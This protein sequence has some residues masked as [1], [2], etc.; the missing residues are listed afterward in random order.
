MGMAASQARY[1]GLQARKTN[2]EF[3][4]QQV[5][6]Q[7]TAL[8]NESAGLFRRM[9]TLNV[10]TPPD[11]TDYKKGNYTFTDAT[12]TNGKATIEDIVKNEGSDPPTYTLNIKRVVDVPQ[13]GA[14]TNQEVSV[15]KDADTNKYKIYNKNGTAFDLTGPISPLSETYVNEFNKLGATEYENDKDDVYYKYTNPATNAT[16][17]INATE[18]GF[19]PE[20]SNTQNVDFFTLMSGQEEQIETIENAT[21]GTTAD[22]A[23]NSIY[24]TDEDGTHYYKLT[25]GSEYDEAGYDQAMADYNNAKVAYEQEI[26]DINAKTEELQE[27]DRTLELRL[28]QLDTEQEALQTELESVKKVIDKNIDNVFKTF[29]S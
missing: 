6:Q 4:G 29:Q 21:L 17:F 16:Y 9:L 15:I 10:P 14:M 13:Y 11:Q 27:T 22:G 1:L 7:R 24:W 19:D 5:N 28:K 20:V 12:S 18:T 26:A 3:E 23:Y 25:A 2:V 8:A